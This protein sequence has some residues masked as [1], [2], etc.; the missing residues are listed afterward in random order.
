MIAKIIL[1]DDSVVYAKIPNTIYHEKAVKAMENEFKK[2]ECLV[3][4]N[5]LLNE[6]NRAIVPCQ[7][8][9]LIEFITGDRESCYQR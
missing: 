2:N 1:I 3:V 4:N 7:N 5:D 8:I 9:K 6:F